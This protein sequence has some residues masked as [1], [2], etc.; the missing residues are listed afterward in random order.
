MT[1]IAAPLRAAVESGGVPGL[2]ALAA[3]R[4]GPLFQGAFGRRSQGDPTPMTE[5]TV[6][7]LA[8]M[9][10]AVTSVAA[11]QLVEEGRI[12]L[13]DPLGAL[14]PEMRDPQVL[15]GFDSAGRPLLRPARGA[16]TLRHLLTH[17]SGYGY[18]H[19]DPLLDRYMRLTGLSGG[20]RTA[21][22][23]PLMFDPGTRWQYGIGTDLVGQVV[24]ALSG[25]RLGDWC[26]ARILG[27]LGMADT[28]FV[29]PA[30]R[31]ARMAGRH[32]RGPDGALT[33]DREAVPP[34]Q[35]EI[36]GGGGG[37]FGT[38]PDYLRFLRMLLNGGTLEGA[39]ILAPETVA[40][41]GQNQIGAVEVPPLPPSSTPGRANLADFFPGM[42]KKW[43]LGFLLNTEAAPGRRAANSLAWGG[44]HNTY[45]WIDPASGV[46]GAV[47]TQIL[48]FADEAVLETFTKFEA[49]VYAGRG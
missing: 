41:M 37:L 3:T 40:A 8:S 13:D 10:K 19:W 28:D 29:V 32:Q 26:R 2:V 16:V 21:K 11:M 30:A 22:G 31:R 17:T 9:T 20:P 4:N 48:P 18:D 36:D 35:I 12:G 49:A 1:D 45:Y 33:L 6:F 27:P 24:E 25:R 15:E 14:L 42:R 43:G 23:M 47:F 5:D 44:I 46:T 34:E 39:R 38:G 7:A